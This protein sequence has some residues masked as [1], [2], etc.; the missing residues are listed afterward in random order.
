MLRILFIILVISL[1]NPLM[2]QEKLKN[3]ASF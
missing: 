3:F 2:A 1:V